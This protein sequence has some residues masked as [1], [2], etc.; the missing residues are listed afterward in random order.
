MNAHPIKLRER[1]LRLLDK[2]HTKA[3][4]IELLDISYDSLER[5]ENLRQ[6]TG[7]L[8]DN[9]PKRTAYKIDR[10]KLAKYYKENPHATNK[11]AAL[12]FNCSETGIFKA[13]KSLKITRKKHKPIHRA[14]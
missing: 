14:R 2:G 4:I 10:D 3:E 8:K 1:A 6:E 11:E 12:V 9:A 5:W 7:S 13:K